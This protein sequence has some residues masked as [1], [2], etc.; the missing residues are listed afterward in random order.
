MA[1][2]ELSLVI[3]AY[4]EEDRLPETLALVRDW[5]E[6]QPFSV[7]VLV[8]DDGS[9]DRT[10]E[11]TRLY[12]E[13]FSALRLVSLPRNQGKGAAVREGMLK[14]TGAWRLMTDADMSTPI[15]EAEHLLAE[16]KEYEV[17]I[18]SRYLKPDSIKVKQPWK[19]RVLSRFGNWL[20][21]Q[22][23][24]LRDIRDTQCGFKLFSAQA[25]EAVYSRQQETGWLFDVEILTI[26]Q[27]LGY[28]IKE[29]PVDWYDSKQSK[30]R[31]VR[32]GW[33]TFHELR[34]ISKRARAGVYRAS[35]EIQ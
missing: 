8:V 21:H 6:Q 27:E 9:R 2:P 7:E 34:S 32:T 22:M 26:A 20:I 19:R 14:A 4:N 11:L 13:R 5:V 29:V 18:G 33:K 1:N 24:G 23:L 35:Q 3:P 28:A 15:A 31:A 10:A 25:A 16:R 12:C 30:L 17:I